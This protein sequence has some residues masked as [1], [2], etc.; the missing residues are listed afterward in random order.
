MRIHNFSNIDNLKVYGND[1]FDYLNEAQT[2]LAGKTASIQTGCLLSISGTKVNVSSG[3]VN[4]GLVRLAFLKSGVGADVPT[5]AD[6]DSVQVSLNDGD[7]KYIVARVLTSSLASSQRYYDLTTQ[8]IGVS[9]LL[10][11][12]PVDNVVGEVVLGKATRSGSTVTLDISER[13]YDLTLKLSLVEQMCNVLA[14][15]ARHVSTFGAVGDGIVNDGPALQRA[16]DWLATNGGGL[17]L[18]SGTYKVIGGLSMSNVDKHIFICGNGATIDSSLDSTTYRML[19]ITGKTTELG[20]ILE[21]ATKLGYTIRLNNDT[22]GLD[23]KVILRQNCVVP[24][25]ATLS[26]QKDDIQTRQYFETDVDTFT[27][28]MIGLSFVQTNETSKI[29]GGW[30]ALI[31]TYVSPRKVGVITSNNNFF[32]SVV[33]NRLLPYTVAANAWGLV[34]LWCPAR[35]YYFKGEI[36]NIRARTATNTYSLQNT[37]YDNYLASSTTATKITKHTVTIT[38]INFKGPQANRNGIYIASFGGVNLYNVKITGY[39]DTNIAIDQSINVNITDC[40]AGDNGLTSSGTNYGLAIISSQNCNYTGGQ[41]Y[42][43]RHG[44]THGG[45]FPCR[46]T[47]VA[48]L[49][50]HSFLTSSLDWHGNAEYCTVSNV[51]CFGGVYFGG[52]NVNATNVT[53]WNNLANAGLPFFCGPER[54]CEYFNVTNCIAHNDYYLGGTAFGF[55]A[56]FVATDLGSMQ[57]QNCNFNSYKYNG[58]L[59]QAYNTSRSVQD[60]SDPDHIK[61][62]KATMNLF[63]CGGSYIR[64]EYG[65]AVYLYGN[66]SGINIKLAVFDNCLLESPRWQVIRCDINPVNY[67]SSQSEKP[68]ELQVTGNELIEDTVSHDITYAL[69]PTNVPILTNASIVNNTVIASTSNASAETKDM[70]ADS[71]V[72]ELMPSASVSPIAFIVDATST[73]GNLIVKNAANLLTI[74]SKLLLQQNNGVTEVTIDACSTMLDSGLYVTTITATTPVQTLAKPL[75][76]GLG[77]QRLA[78]SVSATTTPNFVGA[79]SYVYSKLSGNA[80]NIRG[81]LRTG[82]SGTYVRVRITNLN[83][84]E[85]V[86]NLYAGMFA[87]GDF[88][89]YQSTLVIN[90]CKILGYSDNNAYPVTYISGLKTIRF[91]DNDCDLQK[92]PSSAGYLL[93]QSS[94]NIIYTGNTIANALVSSGINIPINYPAVT[95]NVHPYNNTYINCLGTPGIATADILGTRKDGKLILGYPTF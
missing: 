48:N 10:S 1:F 72:K 6:V 35:A 23:D 92:S 29:I 78:S 65:N 54:D 16:C 17:D 66:G 9:T 5:I 67:D 63:Y 61:M 68:I 60:V 40:Y 95:Q 24:I 25:N 18:G 55:A 46:N 64:S 12:F 69:D 75:W 42:G 30:T 28:D 14:N 81:N 39:R 62:P 33:G 26:C 20:F 45:T 2:N 32:N 19:S 50:T 57:V 86:S 15:S 47:N 88:Y 7:N 31:I 93:L 89:N 85:V 37:L 80:V 49:T 74:G 79:T 27:P 53:A 43:G 21:D 59:L 87:V 70:I 58:L 36:L 90:G 11:S 56:Q 52:I 82:L 94:N 22:L 71:S 77:G 51:Q 34:S 73:I 76:C 44:I 8:V 4:G 38:G 83:S 84:G 13:S 3:R 91:T 41:Y